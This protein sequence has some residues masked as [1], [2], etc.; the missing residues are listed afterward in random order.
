MPRRARAEFPGAIH[1][2]ITQGNGGGRIVMDDRDR[3][4]L[5]A[6]L[7]AVASE[8]AWRVHAY[9]LMD[10]HLH[11]I[12]ETPEPTLGAGMQRLV[13]GYARA[14]NQRHGRSGHLFGGPYYA[15]PIESDAHLIQACVYVVLNPVRA[16]LVVDPADWRWSS[17]RATAGFES[18]PAFMT[19]EVL[20]GSLA[21]D[22]G[23]ARQ[24]YRETVAG[25]VLETAGSG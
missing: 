16:G 22:L 2:V 21:D 5:I 9:C 17:H 20:P 13:G 25:E 18:M 1:H 14:F 19:T 7:A 15:V 10:T 8:F 6:R 23:R 12:I 3:D 4:E 11:G 24:I